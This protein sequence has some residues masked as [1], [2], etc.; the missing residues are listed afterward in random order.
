VS[1]SGVGAAS[2]E[3]D[4]T[5]KAR[6]RLGAVLWIAGAVQFVL[7]MVVVQLAWTTPY[8]IATNAISDLGAV[9]CAENSMG[10]SYVCSP[11]HVVFNASII[12][13]GVLVAVGALATR[14][15]FPPTRS[16][17]WA[18]PILVVAGSG[19]LLV[20]LFPED[21]IGTLH[22]LGAT[23]AFVGSSAAML[24]FAVSMSGRPRWSGYRQL[25]LGCG[26][27]SGATIVASGI[28]ES[29]GPIGFGGLERMIVAPAI[30]WLMV[31][32]ARLAANP[33]R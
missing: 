23:M 1:T 24:L 13:F 14:P 19:A 33:T 17:A 22:A 30:L 6:V 25:S 20:G 32:G 12:L 27:F 16:S 15:G 5:T 31:L 21:T 29:W 2:R 11:L 4:P 18:S 28:R 8:D 3:E 26:L 10:T 7:T 9:S